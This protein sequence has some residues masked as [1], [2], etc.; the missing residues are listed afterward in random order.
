MAFRKVYCI[1][2]IKEILLQFAIFSLKPP[3]GV[4]W[5]EEKAGSKVKIKKKIGKVWNILKFMYFPYQVFYQESVDILRN[6]QW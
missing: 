5:A 6:K 2:W 3:G 4:C 1:K